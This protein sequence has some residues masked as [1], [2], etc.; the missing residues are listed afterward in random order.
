MKFI[1]EGK[2]ILGSNVQ[3]FVKEIDAIS[4]KRAEEIVLRKIGS[5]HKLKSTQIKIVSIKEWTE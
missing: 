4:K 5:D 3:P 2:F 1:V